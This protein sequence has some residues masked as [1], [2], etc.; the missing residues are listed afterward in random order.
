MKIEK[1]DDVEVLR[2][3]GVYMIDI[4]SHILPGLDDGAQSIEET[5]MIVRQLQDVGFNTLIATPHVLEG[6]GFISPAEI[7]AAT[8]Q[9]RT[10]VAQAGLSVEVLPGAEN[11][12]FPNMAKW[13][14]EGKLLTLGNTGKYLLIELPLLELPLYTDQVFFELQANGMIPVLA[15]PERQRVLANEPDR[16]LDWAQKGVLFQLDLRSLSGKYGPQAKWLAKMMLQSDLINFIGSDAHRVS[17]SASTY[18][19]ALQIVKKISG[20]VGFCEV[21]LTNSRSIVEGKPRQD[22]RDYSSIKPFFIRR[23]S[24]CW[25]LFKR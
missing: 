13:A 12:I 24:K 8:Q 7:L 21:T 11:Y 1:I 15:H 14:R 16:L 6:H 18:L 3:W 19:E 10:C 2:Q 9:V 5:L 20:E 17:Q 25:G 23:S 4:H 22:I